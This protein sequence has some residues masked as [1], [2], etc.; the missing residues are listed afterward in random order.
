MIGS[1]RRA[2]RQVERDLVVYGAVT[3]EGLVSRSLAGRRF[4]MILLGVFAGLAL[5]L[6]S[7]GIFGVVS[8]LV[9]QRTHEFGVRMALGARRRDVLRQVL[10]QGARMA[11]AGAAAGVV[12]ALGLT[13]LATGLLFGVEPTDPP[14]FVAVA[15]LLCAVALAACYVPARRAMRLDPVAALRHE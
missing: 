3:M 12:A 5:A 14:T 15:A 4:A 9:G 6:A 13:R 8:Y 10:G 1:I 11:L 7:V 2:A